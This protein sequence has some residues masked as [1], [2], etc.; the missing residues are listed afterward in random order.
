MDTQIEQKKKK[1]FSIMGLSIWRILV[2]FIIYSFLGYVIETLFGIIT[3]GVWESRQ[4]F[5]YGP[6]CGIYGLGAC[7]IIVLLNKFEKRDS[8]IF[9]GGFI[10][11]SIVEYICSYIGEAVYGVTW[12][13]YSNR[14]FNINGRICV[15]F[16]I[17]W[18]LLSI[19]LIMHLNPKI[20]KLIDNIKNKFSM[21]YL[22]PLTITVFALLIIDCI[23]TGFALKYFFVRIIHNNNIEVSSMDKVN[24]LYSDIYEN[25]PKLADFIYKFWND[26]KMI[27]TF[28]NLK[29]KD[30][31]GDI[32]YFDN[33]VDIQPYYLK[34]YDK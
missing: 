33:Y 22:K 12:W 4:S 9:F 5:L 19:Y 18:G 28:P 32:K 7:A 25:N 14:P 11:G 15:S 23:V 31:N 13:D 30:V 34:I 16:S 6:F 17:F 29:I 10:V 21:K 26:K 20:D 24:T 3:K 2:Y 27:K 1:S 8:V